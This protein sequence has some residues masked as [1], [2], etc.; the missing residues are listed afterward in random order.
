MDKY[1]ACKEYQAF[2]NGSQERA[3]P[4]PVIKILEN[5]ESVEYDADDY[6]FHHCRMKGNMQKL[7]VEKQGN[8]EHGYFKYSE[9]Y[10]ACPGA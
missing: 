9:S 7:V 6:R 5:Y 3:Y 10:K 2:Q 4:V 1:A 8:D